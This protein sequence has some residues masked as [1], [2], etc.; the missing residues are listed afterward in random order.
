MKKKGNKKMPI[1]R[2]LN[3]AVFMLVDAGDAFQDKWQHLLKCV[4]ELLI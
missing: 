2:L 4:Q 3:I 1:N